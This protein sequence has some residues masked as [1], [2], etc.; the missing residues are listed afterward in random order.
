MKKFLIFTLA[1]ALLMSLSVP[2]FA[3]E[4]DQD[5][6]GGQTNLS[7]MV[8]G[9][10]Y[11]VTIPAALNLTTGDNLLPIEVSDADLD[12]KTIK[13]TF[14]GTGDAFSATA[15]NL[16]L[17][18]SGGGTYLEYNLFDSTGSSIGYGVATKGTKLAEFTSDGTKNI[19][20]YIAP[21]VVTASWFQ[22]GIAYTG[23]ITFGI[24]LA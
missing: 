5:D 12:G 23:Y 11:T 4:Y 19:K 16:N 21:S 1:L 14:E 13:V 17:F 18:P 22:K 7:F 20:I 3:T 8:A 9:P 24:A 2:A 10:T 15:Y 6:T